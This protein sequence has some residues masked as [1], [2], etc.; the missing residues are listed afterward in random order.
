MLPVVISTLLFRWFVIC[1]LPVRIV[2]VVFVFVVVV[3]VDVKE[4]LWSAGK[5]SFVKSC[6][7]LEHLIAQELNTVIDVCFKV[8]FIYKKSKHFL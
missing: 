8:I 7:V 3:D 1:R 6:F 2:V 5:L 4:F